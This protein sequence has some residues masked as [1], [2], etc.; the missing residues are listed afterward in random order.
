MM[1]ILPIRG[2]LISRGEIKGKRKEKA[3]YKENGS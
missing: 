3:R 1:M 2:V